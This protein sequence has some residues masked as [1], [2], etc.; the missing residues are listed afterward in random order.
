MLDAKRSKKTYSI[1]L[2]FPLSKIRIFALR[3][4]M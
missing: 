3:K 1:L 4:Y 2:N